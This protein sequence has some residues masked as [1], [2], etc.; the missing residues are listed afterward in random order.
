MAMRV[1]NHKKGYEKMTKKNEIDETV[2]D[3]ML[4]NQINSLNIEGKVWLSDFLFEIA[5][6]NFRGFIRE[7]KML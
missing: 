6:R 5:L 4:V 1:I 3:K 2:L 7:D